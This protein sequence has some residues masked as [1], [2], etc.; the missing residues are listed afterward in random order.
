MF[1]SQVAKH[2]VTWYAIILKGQRAKNNDRV[3][4]KF[5]MESTQMSASVCGYFI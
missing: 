3:T 2:L 5:K 4:L 1:W